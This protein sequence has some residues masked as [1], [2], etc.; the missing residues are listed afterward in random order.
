MHGP[1]E[2][3]INIGPSFLTYESDSAILQYLAEIF[4]L[5]CRLISLI[6]PG[7]GIFAE[8]L[9]GP[10]LSVS[11]VLFLIFIVAL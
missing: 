3:L 7:E 2:A 4:F 9:L 6:G 1:F 8:V 5:P 11:Y 10:A